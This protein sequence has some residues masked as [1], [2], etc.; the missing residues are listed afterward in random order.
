[1]EYHHQ[2]L[3]LESRNFYRTPA[4]LATLLHS[5]NT[6]DVKELMARPIYKKKMLQR[7]LLC[8][9]HHCIEGESFHFQCHFQ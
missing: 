5:N 6:K 1:M 9:F 2:K 8:E 3:A 7:F 4:Y